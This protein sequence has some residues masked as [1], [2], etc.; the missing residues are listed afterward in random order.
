MLPARSSQGSS[1][2]PIIVLIAT[3]FVQLLLLRKADPG[4]AR[5]TPSLCALAISDGQLETALLLLVRAC[6]PLCA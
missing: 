5:G 6:L 2:I 3:F 1:E 4:H